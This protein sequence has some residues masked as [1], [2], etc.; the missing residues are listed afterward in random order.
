MTLILAIEPDDSFIAAAR[1]ALEGLGCRLEVAGSGAEG[2]DAAERLSPD[3]CLVRAELPDQT[4]FSV[5]DQLR[6]M[7]G[8]HQRPVVI[9]TSDAD[10]AVIAAHG[11]CRDGA[12]AYL[13]RP[14]TPRSLAREVAELLELDEPPSEAEELTVALADHSR[15]VRRTAEIALD[16]SG[17]ELRTHE[18][19]AELLESVAAARPDV[20]LVDLGLEDI[21]GYEVCRRLRATDAGR[22]LPLVALWGASRPYEPASGRAAGVTHALRKP[23][24]TD[25]LL[26]TLRR[27]HRG[28]PPLPEPPLLGA[29]RPP[30]GAESE[31]IE[32]V[33][34][35]DGTE[36]YSDL[37]EVYEDLIVEIIAERFPGEDEA[38]AS[39]EAEGSTKKI[40]AFE[41]DAGLIARM[42]RIFSRY[43]CTFDVTSDGV[44]G[45]AAVTRDPPDL[46]LLSVELPGAN[47]FKLCADLK[48]SSVHRSIPVIILSA[49][50]TS[51]SIERHR[52]L[53]SRADDYLIKPFDGRSMIER[54]QA[55]IDLHERPGAQPLAPP[56]SSGAFEPERRRH[57]VD[58]G[59]ADSV[60]YSLTPRPTGSSV[61]PLDEPIVEV[62]DD[63]ELEA[64][65]NEQWLIILW[66]IDPRVRGKRYDISTIGIS[67]DEL[68]GQ[69]TLPERQL[70]ETLVTVGRN[71]QNRVVVVDPRLS[72]WHF[73]IQRREGKLVLTDLDSA[74]GT[75]VDDQRVSRC[76]LQ[77]G[78]IIRFGSTVAKFI[79]DIELSSSFGEVIREFSETD[80]PTGTLQRHVLRQRLEELLA[81]TGERER[82]LAVVGVGLDDIRQLSCSQGDLAVDRLVEEV[83]QRVRAAFPGAIVGR[84]AGVG[85][86]VVLPDQSAEAARAKADHLRQTIAVTPLDLDG[87]EVAVTLSLGVVERRAGRE[88]DATLRTLNAL[89]TEAQSAGGDRVLSEPEAAPACFEWSHLLPTSAGPAIPFPLA[90]G[91]P[92]F[93]GQPD[94]EDRI[95]LGE[96][97]LELAWRFLATTLTSALAAHDDPELRAAVD[98][99]LEASGDRPLRLAADPSLVR[100]LAVLARG[101]DDDLIAPLAA[102]FTS[103]PGKR[104]I[105]RSIAAIERVDA[106]ASAGDEDRRRLDGRLRNLLR[107]LRDRASAALEATMVSVEQVLGFEADGTVIYSVWRL[108]GP[109]PRFGKG[110]LALPW[111][112]NPGWC[113]LLVGPQ[114][115]PLVLAPLFAIAPDPTQGL[116]QLF[117]GDRLSLRVDLDEL[118]LRGVLDDRVIQRPVPQE[119]LWRLR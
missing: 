99:R 57:V 46:I 3:L 68:V 44:L 6:A 43:D 30:S 7:S 38:E 41:A 118:P 28:A 94:R 104:L 34:T 110:R 62:S 8:G 21:D 72:S 90:L 18:R 75:W 47:G 50:Q 113:T 70:A 78:E 69:P 103:R 51:E 35:V 111:R 115:R 19:G 105:S 24:D 26:E 101:R 84:N 87:T 65:V 117:V 76:E 5:C 12:D 40:F 97:A 89:I 11:A 45:L 55:L 71:P 80:W 98:Q 96:R 95:E 100:D 37:V 81:R 86:L 91:P 27:L 15:T 59:A 1:P 48:R 49:K 31:E 20:A 39:A 107:D 32:F 17:L 109:S 9:I 88:V 13:R 36:D 93:E 54:V 92:W 108:D 119:D 74:T 67:A 33:D 16:G 2:L 66:S 73:R 56:P 116:P 63:L 4:G 85:F 10:E 22:D 106:L 112:V 64:L 61:A 53:G 82:P 58:E 42:K 83:G 25:H 102:L 29:P 52:S 114:R 23:F 77:G 60:V 14:L 79:N